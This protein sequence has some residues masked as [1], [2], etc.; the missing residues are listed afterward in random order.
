MKMLAALIVVAVLASWALWM[1]M[2]PQSAPQNLPAWSS[3][4]SAEVRDISISGAGFPLTHL[5][6]QGKHWLLLDGEANGAEK[7]GVA[8]NDEAVNHLLAS[9]ADM[10]L[11]RVVTHHAEHFP[12]LGLDEA[13]GIHVVLRDKHGSI[14]L[15]I[16]VGKPA[17]DLI[18]TYVRRQGVNEAVT[19]NRSLSWQLKRTH[20]TWQAPPESPEP[21]LGAAGSGDLP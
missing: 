5:Q 3:F 4:E 1:Q 9:L 10:R 12:R 19:V 7:H 18:S 14:L 11:V 8:A 6:Q 13:T 16:L 15:D 20:D 17:V 21:A 2:R